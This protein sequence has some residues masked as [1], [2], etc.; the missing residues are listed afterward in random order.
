MEKHLKVLIE[1][2]NSDGDFSDPEHKFIYEVGLANGVNE[3][4]IKDLIEEGGTIKDLGVLSEDQK[5]EYLYNIT[6]LMK[7]DGKIFKQEIELCKRIANH[8]GYKSNVIAELS[9]RIYGDPKITSNKEELKKK[10]QKFL[11]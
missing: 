1:L 4:V 5:F 11:I 10:V 6:Q 8:L 7:V 9:T 2:A 3:K